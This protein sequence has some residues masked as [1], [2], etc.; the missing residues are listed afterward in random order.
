MPGG[1]TRRLILASALL[2][3]VIAGAFAVLLL[4]LD[5]MRD[6]GALARHS[7]S[8]LVAA[9]QLEKLVIDIETGQRGFIIT[10]D[11]R[12]LAPWRAARR[13]IPATGRRLLMLTDDPSRGCSAERPAMGR[14]RA[15]RG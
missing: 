2:V 3:V 14:E 13:R 10:G 6:S 5:S 1:L 4:A 8:E 9:S 12:F 11:A 7:R 15:R